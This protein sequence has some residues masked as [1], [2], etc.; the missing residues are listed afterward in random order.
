M[1]IAALCPSD[2][3]ISMEHMLNMLKWRYLSNWSRLHM[4]ASTYRYHCDDF[5]KHSE[6]SKSIFRAAFMNLITYGISICNAISVIHSIDVVDTCQ[7]DAVTTSITWLPQAYHARWHSFLS[8]SMAFDE[9]L[10]FNNWLFA[11]IWWIFHICACL[12]SAFYSN[13][14]RNLRLNTLTKKVNFRELN[15]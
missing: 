2:N 13:W 1:T 8:L 11:L 6:N 10:T 9:C 12:R 7:M 14:P 3:Q 4:C 5:T 15:A